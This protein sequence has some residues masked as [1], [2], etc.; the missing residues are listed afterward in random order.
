LK[1]KLEEISRNRSQ[2]K[3]KRKNKI[4][5]KEKNRVKSKSGDS[6][7]VGLGLDVRRDGT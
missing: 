5:G 3:D 2:I 4:Y 1:K 7:P 6:K